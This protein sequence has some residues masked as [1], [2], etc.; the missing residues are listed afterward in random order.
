MIDA[1]MIKELTVLVENVYQQYGVTS[2]PKSK[3]SYVKILSKGGLGEALRAMDDVLSS[4][5]V[6]STTNNTWDKKVKELFSQNGLDYTEDSFEDF[7]MMDQ[8]S[9]IRLFKSGLYLQFDRGEKNRSIDNLFKEYELMGKEPAENRANFSAGTKTIYDYDIED[10]YNNKD[11]DNYYSTESPKYQEE[12][13]E[14][15]EEGVYDREIDDSKFFKNKKQMATVGESLADSV[16][17][18][19]KRIND[20]V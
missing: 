16:L 2:V 14:G 4:S 19:I 13:E 20:K 1:K 17:K 3:E 6:E 18:V 9:A 10:I 11:I 15:E 12:S 8:D 7:V 5:F